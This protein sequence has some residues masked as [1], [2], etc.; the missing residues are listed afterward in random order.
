MAAT[1]EGVEHPD[2]LPSRGTFAFITELQTACERAGVPASATGL[3]IP[4]HVYELTSQQLS[5]LGFRLS[6]AI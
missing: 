6:A 5:N 4:G 2:Y 3:P 1:I